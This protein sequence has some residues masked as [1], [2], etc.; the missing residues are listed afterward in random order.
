MIDTH[1]HLNFEQFAHDRDDVI[2]R[3]RGA[4]VEI[5]INVGADVATSIESQQLAAAY[6][7]VYA[8][9]G[10]HPHYAE[11]VTKEDVAQLA[12]LTKQD[13]VIA[14]G[15]VGLDYYDREHLKQKVTASLR[16]KQRDVLE[17]FMQLGGQTKLP[18]IFHCRQAQ[19]DMTAV[20]RNIGQRSLRGVIHC[21]CQDR[22]FLELCLE[23]GLFISFTGNITYKKAEN[24]REL[25]KFMPLERLLLETD[26]PY[27]APQAVRGKRNE[28]AYIEFTAKEIA[29][30]K[31]L[32][33]EEVARVTTLNAKTLFNI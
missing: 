2:K 8:S 14:I 24:L 18:L 17:R 22:K 11:R 31:N 29:R 25:V 16:S 6:E 3:A 1:C 10:I 26:A 9:V 21:F 13:E 15:E 27:L 28:P 23:C 7:G 20:V 33:F 32:D 30:I 5:I 19:E 12:S 4:G